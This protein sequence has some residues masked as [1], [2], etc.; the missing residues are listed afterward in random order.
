MV[1]LRETSSWAFMN[2]YMYIHMCVGMQDIQY[3]QIFN[4]QSGS[5]LI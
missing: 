3:L 1:K 4:G 2:V 5:A